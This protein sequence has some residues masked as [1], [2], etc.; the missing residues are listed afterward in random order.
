MLERIC[1]ISGVSELQLRWI[2]WMHHHASILS[3]ITYLTYIAFPQNDFLQTTLGAPYYSHIIEA[4]CWHFF[5]VRA[6]SLR[7]CWNISMSRAQW[8]WSW[9][10]EAHPDGPVRWIWA[11]GSWEVG[12]GGSTC[13]N[14]CLVFKKVLRLALRSLT[15]GSISRD[16]L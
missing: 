14:M 13:V 4:T 1:F 8:P 10:P 15:S 5:S 12:L 16:Q 9:S 3:I 7:S 2:S 6:A 11:D